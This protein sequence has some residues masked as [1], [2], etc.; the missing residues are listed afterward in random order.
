[1]DKY[2]VFV[3]DSPTIAG[4]WNRVGYVE[5]ES[6]QEAIAKAKKKHGDKVMVRKVK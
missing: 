3:P 2:K 5:A 1:M 6:E 4:G